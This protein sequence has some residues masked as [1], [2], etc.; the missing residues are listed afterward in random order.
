MPKHIPTIITRKGNQDLLK[1]ID[2][3]EMY[4]VVW[5]LELDKALGHDGFSIHF[6]ISF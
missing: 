1:V 3:E 2:E 5:T 6:F 4:Q